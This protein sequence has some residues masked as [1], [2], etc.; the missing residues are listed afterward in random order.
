M[1]IINLILWL[2]FVMCFLEMNSYFLLIFR[3]SPGSDL[4]D[5]KSGV[6][7]QTSTKSFYDFDLI[8]CVGRP[9]PICAPVWPR[10]DLRS[11]SRSFRS[12]KNCTFL[13]LSLLPLWCAAHN[14]CLSVIVWP[15]LQC[16]WARFSTFLLGKLSW[17][18]RLCGMSTLRDIQMAIFP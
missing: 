14:W 6:S 13:G 9:R 16:I 17:E 10:P 7:V 18:F 1:H 12:C 3:S 2:V 15:G 11:R 8:W 4:V 5:W